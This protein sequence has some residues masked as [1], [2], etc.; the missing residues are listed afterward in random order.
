MRYD[1]AIKL[2]EAALEYARIM[3]DPERA[4]NF[5]KETFRILDIIPLSEHGAA[6]VFSK[7]ETGKKVAVFFFWMNYGANPRW[8]NFTPT[9][10]HIL[11]MESFGRIKAEVEKGNFPMNFRSEFPEEDER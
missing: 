4:K 7:P 8:S 11:A 6:V 3:S 1:V 10:S 5:S 9:D 2:R